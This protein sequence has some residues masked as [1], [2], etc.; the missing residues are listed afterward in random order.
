[1]GAALLSTS[2]S[3]NRLLYRRVDA[4]LLL[5]QVSFPFVFGKFPLVFGKLPFL[6]GNLVNLRTRI[7]A[8]LTSSARLVLTGMNI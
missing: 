8:L 2:V 3:E 6:F 1:M 4:P 7:Q 5:T